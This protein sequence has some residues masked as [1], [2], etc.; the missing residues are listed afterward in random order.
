MRAALLTE[1]GKPLEIVDDV[2]IRDPRP[3]EVL[4]RVK[5]CGICRSDLTVADGAFPSSLPVIL[6]HEAAGVVEQL[7]QGVSSLAVCGWESFM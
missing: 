4:V 7:G 2:E 3:G 5:N 1:V 6:G